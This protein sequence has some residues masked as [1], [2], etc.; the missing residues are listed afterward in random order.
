MKRKP[1]TKLGFALEDRLLAIVKKTIPSSLALKHCAVVSSFL[2]FPI[3]MIVPDLVIIAEAENS[4]RRTVDR[5]VPSLFEC[6]VVA[7]ILKHGPRESGQITKHFYMQPNRLDQAV[8]RLKRFGLL[9]TNTDG[10]LVARK[11]DFPSSVKIIS[12]E[13]KLR[14]WKEA[15]QQA[16]TYFQFSNNSYVALPKAMIEINDKIKRACRTEGIGLIAVNSTRAEILFNGK[17]VKPMTAERVW[18]IRKTSALK[19]VRRIP[20][21]KQNAYKTPVTATKRLKA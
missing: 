6:A 13:A 21:N 15:I 18:L 14:R 12:I 7:E 3:G 2:K 16:K 5:R 11:R 1:K 17:S 8:L 10:A 9:T 20:L 4:C 19:G